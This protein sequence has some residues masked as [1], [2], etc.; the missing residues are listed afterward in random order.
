MGLDMYLYA[1]RFLSGYQHTRE[2]KL[3]ERVREVTTFDAMCAMLGVKASDNAPAIDVSVCVGYWQ[4][5][6]AIH[7]WF[8]DNAQDG[9][10]D[11][12]EYEV[13]REDLAKL[14][15][16][17]ALVLEKPDLT[18]GVVMVGKEIRDGKVSPVTEMGKVLADTTVASQVLP[19]RGGFFF[20]TTAYTDEYL[21]DARDTIAIIGAALAMPEC[22]F[23]KY[24]ASW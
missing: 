7:K 2:S 6:N 12:D 20:G 8:V 17:C 18:D 5:A 14:R 15:D 1:T 19:T 11:C 23:F 4:K 16:V 21:Q 22:W 24:R 9:K 13:S 10:D 3:P